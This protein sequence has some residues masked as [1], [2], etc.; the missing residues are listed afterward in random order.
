MQTLDAARALWQEEE[1]TRL[2]TEL[3]RCYVCFSVA[4]VLHGQLDSF[5]ERAAF[6]FGEPGSSCC[7]FMTEDADYVQNVKAHRTGD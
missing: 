3:S 4:H 6:L 7:G 1:C 5:C 2:V